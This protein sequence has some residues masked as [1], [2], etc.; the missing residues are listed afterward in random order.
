MVFGRRGGLR[1]ELESCATRI[2][3]G[4]GNFCGITEACVDV[5]FFE[6]LEQEIKPEAAMR[7]TRASLDRAKKR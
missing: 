6:V 4:L 1:R 5:V 3:A 7:S 2:G